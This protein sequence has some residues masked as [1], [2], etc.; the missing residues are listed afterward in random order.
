MTDLLDPTIPRGLLHRDWMTPTLKAG[1]T[2]N[3]VMIPRGTEIP[4]WLSRNPNTTNFVILDDLGS[5]HFPLMRA[6]HVMCELAKGFTEE[7]SIQ[8]HKILKT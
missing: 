4:T 3:E 1:T 7:R 5:K 6:R 2:E 8:A